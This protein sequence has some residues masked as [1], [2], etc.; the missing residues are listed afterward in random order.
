MPAY[1]RLIEETR[2]DQGGAV[3][4]VTF[5]P[6]KG[7]QRPAE[8][9]KQRDLDASRAEQAQ[10]QRNRVIQ[11][12]LD[13]CERYLVQNELRRARIKV[14]QVLKELDSDLPLAEKDIDSIKNAL[15]A[16]KGLL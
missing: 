10:M 1:A 7:H 8:R 14:N 2:Y 11:G 12:R 9:R 5:R 13:Q 4:V 16:I 15:E 3:I 6:Q